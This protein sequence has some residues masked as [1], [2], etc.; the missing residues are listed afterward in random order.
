[1]IQE[2]YEYINNEPMVCHQCPNLVKGM[3]GVKAGMSKTING[4]LEMHYL[5]PNGF[6]LEESFLIKRNDLFKKIR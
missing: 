3:I 6:I 4:K 5:F 2:R 1:M